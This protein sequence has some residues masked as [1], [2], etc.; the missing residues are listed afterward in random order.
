MRRAFLLD[1]RFIEVAA[2]QLVVFDMKVLVSEG[3]HQS[4][5]L[6]ETETL[7]V[8]ERRV[9]A[10]TANANMCADKAPD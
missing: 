9:R 3:S 4:R 1:E 6:I 8:F 5:S 2:V 10:R 7:F